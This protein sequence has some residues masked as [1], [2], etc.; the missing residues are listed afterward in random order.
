MTY[1]NSTRVARNGL[2]DRFSTLT[3]TIRTALRQRRLYAQAV[4]ELST[5]SDRELADLGISRLSI[6]DVAREAAYGK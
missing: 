1:V 6:A 2:A 5:L 3:E 4:R